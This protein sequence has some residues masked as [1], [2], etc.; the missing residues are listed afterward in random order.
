MGID[1]FQVKK[2]RVFSVSARLC[3][4]ERHAQDT[5]R[6]RVDAGRIA[7]RRGPGAPGESRDHRGR[8]GGAFRQGLGARAEGEGRMRVVVSGNGMVGQ[9]FLEQ[10][11]RR[12]RDFEITAFCDEPRPAY[13]RVQ[14]T[15]FFSGKTAT[16]LSLVSKGFF[17]ESNVTL[18]LSD[19]V[20]AI[21]AQRKVVRSARYREV[22]YGKLVLATGSYPFVPPVSGKDR[23]DCF[24]YRTIEDLEV[25]TAAAAR[26]KVGTVIGGGLLGLEA[27]KALKDLG[28]ETH[29]VEF[30]SRLMAVQLDDSAGRLLRRK[31]EA[32]GAKVHLQK[33]TKEIVDGAQRRQ[34]LVYADGTHLETDLIVFSAGIRPRDEL[35]RAA[36]LAVGE[37]GGVQI[38]SGCRTSNPDVYAIGE[39]ALW[40]GRIFGLVA[41]GYQMAEVAARNLLGEEVQFLGADMSTKLKLMGVDVASIG[42]AHGATPD[43]LNYVFTDEVAGVYKKLVVS[44][45][46]KHALG[47]ILVGDASD[48]GALLQ[49][50]INGVPLP[51]HPEELILPLRA[52][53]A[54]GVGADALPDSALICSCNSVSKGQICDAVKAGCT[55]LGALKKAT[56]CATSCGGCGPLAKSLI[57]LQLKKQGIAVTNHL[58]EHFAHSRQELFHLVKVNGIR[59]FDELVARHGKGKGCDICKPAVASILAS[60]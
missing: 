45:D 1:L 26:G 53:G 33:S 39:C 49:L 32:L 43:A 56:K 15:S 46:R 34:R 37:R 2:R 58:C 8:G 13:D 59:T 5:A 47:A 9:R 54:K 51:E 30:A 55:T 10:L 27:A 3:N 24:V 35:A 4:R 38:D 60:C 20:L 31:I 22:P 36:G 48:Y 28:L 44:P 14:L 7:G 11:V 6:D 57:D 19:A 50:A 25:I 41:P 42:D 40:Q 29:V 16:D 52:G 23:R 12:S 17:E 18:R 21:D